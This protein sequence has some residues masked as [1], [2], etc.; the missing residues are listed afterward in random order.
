VYN[1]TAI[2]SSFRSSAFE[3][4]G[5][6]ISSSILGI[7]RPKLKSSDMKELVHLYKLGNF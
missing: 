3:V 6:F 5:S 4:R 1:T 2:T 7:R